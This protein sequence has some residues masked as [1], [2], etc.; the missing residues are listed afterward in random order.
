MMWR[1]SPD[2][3]ENNETG[4]NRHPKA[5]EEEYQKTIDSPPAIR[6]PIAHTHARPGF[7]ALAAY[8]RYV[9]NCLYEQEDRKAAEASGHLPSP[10]AA[11]SRRAGW[12]SNMWGSSQN[13]FKNV[14]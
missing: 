1:A 6:E 9:H 5:T 11:F 4:K 13:L 7:I 2:H 12:A 3:A 10:P 8:G 14:R